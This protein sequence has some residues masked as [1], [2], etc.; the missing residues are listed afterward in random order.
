V[1][2]EKPPSESRLKSAGFA[3][4]VR[5]A[6]GGVTSEQLR[7]VCESAELKDP[8]AFAPEF[9]PRA[10]LKLYHALTGVANPSLDTI[11]SYWE[12]ALGPG[13]HQINEPFFCQG[14]LAG[15]K[16][17]HLGQPATK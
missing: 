3:A 2:R 8:N 4:G 6:K 12:Q 9:D 7:A 17:H 15:L 16:Y 14:L 5:L 13:W 10:A 11:R 1:T